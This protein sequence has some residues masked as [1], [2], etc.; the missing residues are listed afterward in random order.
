MNTAAKL[1]YALQG[2]SQAI[3]QMCARIAETG[4]T[5]DDA[6]RLAYKLA[7]YIELTRE[8]EHAAGTASF[9]EEIMAELDAIAADEED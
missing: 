9:A 7:D 2:L 1:S 4:L 8:F 5:D 3:R 6:E